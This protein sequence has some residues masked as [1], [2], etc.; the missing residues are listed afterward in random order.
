MQIKWNLVSRSQSPQRDNHCLHRLPPPSSPP[1]PAPPPLLHRRGLHI[2][3]HH[4]GLYSAVAVFNPTRPS[5][6]PS[7]HG[8]GGP[9]LSLSPLNGDFYSLCLRWHG[10][11]PRQR[12]GWGVYGTAVS[13]SAT[14]AWVSRFVDGLPFIRVSHPA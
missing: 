14:I 9:Q 5:Q 8:L 11:S 1:H 3:P 6:P 13:S 2:P 4:R 12:Q 7:L 10:G